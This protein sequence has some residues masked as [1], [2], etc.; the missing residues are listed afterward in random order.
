MIRT[1]RGR[2]A[3]ATT[4]IASLMLASTI[5]AGAAPT[6]GVYNAAAAKLVPSALKHTTLQVATDATYPPTSRSAVR[7]WWALT[8]T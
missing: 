4:G 1:S 6:S 5:T 3:L 8:S 7:R 2:W